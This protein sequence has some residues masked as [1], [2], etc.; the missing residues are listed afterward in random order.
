MSFFSGEAASVPICVYLWPNR[1]LL[2]SNVVSQE[3][4]V[5]GAAGFMIFM[6]FMVKIKVLG[7]WFFVLG[8]RSR[9]APLIGFGA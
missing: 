6:P 1:F 2:Q 5:P 3:G 7:A 4:G 8:S 9:F